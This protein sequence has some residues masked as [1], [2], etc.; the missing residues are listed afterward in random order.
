MH[1]DI[2][3][4]EAEFYTQMLR[5]LRNRP[6]ELTVFDMGITLDTADEGPTTCGFTGCAIGSAA[7]DPWFQDRGLTPEYHR[8]PNPNGLPNLWSPHGVTFQGD[9]VHFSDR[10][11]GLKRA[12]H[13]NRWAFSALFGNRYPGS[14]DTPPAKVAKAIE[15]YLEHGVP[16][17]WSHDPY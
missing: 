7:L 14:R 9:T 2:N 5:V 17:N 8:R 3:P 12:F 11:D 4:N 15:Y 6:K 16:P 13:L 10:P 1:P